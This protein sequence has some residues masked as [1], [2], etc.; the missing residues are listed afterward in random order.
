MDN[1]LIKLKQMEFLKKLT[2]EQVAEYVRTE[3]PEAYGEIMQRYQAKLIRYANYL[4]RNDTEAADVVQGSLIKAFANLNS[5]DAKKKFS[6]WIYRIVHNEAINILSKRKNELP[7]LEDMDFENNDNI[8][9]D[10]VREET[11]AE[12]HD[13]LSKMSLLYAEPL[14]LHFLEGRSYDEISDILRLPISTIGT[15]INRAKV[16]MKKICQKIKK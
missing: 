12:V 4:I 10:F 14:S 16:L 9:A 3:N 6:S 8:E 1:G 7:I 13:C 2:D 5:F 11:R 15:R